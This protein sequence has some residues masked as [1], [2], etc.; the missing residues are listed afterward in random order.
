M[1]DILKSVV[2]L[3]FSVREARAEHNRLYSQAVHNAKR[4][5]S[6]PLA[7]QYPSLA[8][9]SPEKV[10]TQLAALQ[11]E[12]KLIKAIT[13]LSMKE[14]LFNISI[15][16][17]KKNKNITHFDSRFDSIETKHEPRFDK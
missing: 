14:T 2:T 5:P 15:D 13:I 11:S 7:T 3:G 16:L 12:L 17:A 4:I 8:P 10:N 9:T 1:K 6:G